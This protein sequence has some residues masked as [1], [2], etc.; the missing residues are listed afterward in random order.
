MKKI[1]TLLCAAVV[2]LSAS[3]AL[4]LSGVQLEKKSAVKQSIGLKKVAPMKKADVKK[5][6]QATFEIS[7]NPDSLTATSARIDVAPSDAN[8]LYYFDVITKANSDAM[9]DAQIA[10]NTKSGIDQYI[11]YYAQYGY[12]A[13]YADFLSQGIDGYT[14][15]KL[16]P[17][18]TYVAFALQ[19]DGTT[20][21][22]I[23]N[24]TRVEFTTPDIAPS[25]DTLQVVV[26]GLR[27]DESSFATQGWWQLAG[28]YNDSTCYVTM[29]NIGGK[30][31][32][33]G[34]YDYSEM[35]PNYTYLY[36]SG[37]KIAFVKGSLTVSQNADQT[38]HIDAELYDATGTLFQ[39]SLDSKLPTV[40]ENVISMSYDASSRSVVI[41]TTNNDPY[42]FYIESK[43]EYDQYQSDTTQTSLIEEI[44][45]WIYQMTQYQALSAFTFVGNKTV[46][47]VDFFG[48]YAAT[49]DY[50][51]LAAPL[52]GVDV[53]GVAKFLVFHFDYPEDIENT[54][55][56][57]KAVKKFENGAL[58]IE[59][60][61]VKYNA[62]GA[63][64]K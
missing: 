43:A 46:S 62:Q 56:E 20:G 23:G 31:V 32:I 36:I 9:T 50:I 19:M 63:I 59:K 47:C 38:Y 64:L 37:T 7:V 16:I 22:L 2:A 29:S 26:N 51:A 55:V 60:N 17:N 58:I 57:L 40:S 53:N 11:A 35:D 14:F 34:L 27:W 61:G 1:F 42:F 21:A 4:D 13:T 12:Q 30:T 24:V 10:A 41:T 18:T 33:E 25:G 49:D 52:D 6:L 5:A 45:A 48:Q 8:V 39:I 15:T 28:Y 3:A 54:E 44:N